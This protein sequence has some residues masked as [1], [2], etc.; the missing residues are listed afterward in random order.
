MGSFRKIHGKRGPLLFC[1]PDSIALG[2][3]PAF[4]SMTLIGTKVSA[5]R[6]GKRAGGD[7]SGA[8][9][10]P[11]L[12]IVS[13]TFPPSPLQVLTPGIILM[14]P[15][16]KLFHRCHYRIHS[17]PPGKGCRYFVLGSPRKALPLLLPLRNWLPCHPAWNVGRQLIQS[18]VN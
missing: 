3:L 1:F 18:W 17:L 8:H 4:L 12:P 2:P 10:H 14:E 6:G 9:P 16:L 5:T 11:N 7:Q 13:I 15:P